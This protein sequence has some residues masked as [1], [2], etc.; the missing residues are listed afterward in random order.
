MPPQLVGWASAKAEQR[1]RPLRATSAWLYHTHTYIYIIHIS[2]IIY[3]HTHTY[4][5]IYHICNKIVILSYPPVHLPFDVRAT[6]LYHYVKDPGLQNVM[7]SS[8]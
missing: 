2:Y 6:I 4:I 7:A 1:I 5:Y 3:I 8:L